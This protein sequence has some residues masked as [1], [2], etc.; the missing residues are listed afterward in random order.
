MYNRKL[1]L[2]KEF[3]ERNIENKKNYA[4]KSSSLSELPGWGSSKLASSS[5]RTWK[6]KFNLK[7]H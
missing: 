7:T 5:L 2:R 1:V 4:N 6:K 3:F